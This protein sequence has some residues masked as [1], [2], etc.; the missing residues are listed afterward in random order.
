MLAAEAA[1]WVKVGG[2]ADV[3]AEL[4][5]ALMALG[6]EA[7]LALPLHPSLDASG[8][9]LR[10]AGRFD[11][12]SRAGPQ[13]C[14]LLTAE[15]NGLLL[16]LIDGQ[17]VRSAARVY[18]DPEA[19]AHKYILFSLAALK[20]CELLDWRPD[21]VHAHDWHAAPAMARLNTC[22][23]ENDFWRHTGTVLTIHNLPFMGSGGQAALDAFG[24]RPSLYPAL[25]DWARLLPLPLGMASADW[26]TTV[27][28]TYAL[29]I[30]TQE[31]GCGLENFVRSRADRLRGILNG[32][33]QARWDPASDPDLIERFTSD[34]L[35]ARLRNKHW[36]QAEF[37]LPIDPT[38]PL[39]AMV[40]RI[41]PQKGVDLALEALNQLS[42]E[43]WQVVLLGTGDPALEAQVKA[44]AADHRDRARA[45]LRFD[46]AL[47]R[48]LYGGADALLVPS[49]YE[50]CGL[51][52][53]IAMRYG[54]L[55]IV[56]AVGG[57]RDTVS[58]ETGF[59]FQ[60][61]E[62]T[63]LAQAV[64]RALHL[65]RRPAEWRE[66]QQR[67]MAADFGWERPARQFL[68]VYDKARQVVAAR[69]AQR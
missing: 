50:P 56:R 59:L 11:I 68:E 48:R 69:A 15:A 65:Y 17:P 49:R 35:Q 55:P 24:L 58:E 34:T 16:L 1:P 43:A 45:L 23:A 25:P 39:L 47:S 46:A 67:A 53:M 32:I 27:S 5:R 41:D 13:S 2:L 64:L 30:Q 6:V 4:P 3:A 57:L 44:F 31:F 33:D 63:E 12:P 14:E 60:R 10:F 66:R 28:P 40:T 36:L 38:T 26:L 7:R 37:G 52:Q 51:A 9:T 18:G 61:P 19:D 20:A 62:A 54:C 29:E 21:V 8:L 42:Q 22:R